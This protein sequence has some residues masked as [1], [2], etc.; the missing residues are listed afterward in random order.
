[1]DSVLSPSTKEA[2]AVVLALPNVH[3][4]AT[5]ILLFTKCVLAFISSFH[6]THNIFF[7]LNNMQLIRE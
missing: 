4:A 7:N 5:T 2:R 1:M 6:M 3:K